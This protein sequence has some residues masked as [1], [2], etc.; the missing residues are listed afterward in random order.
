MLPIMQHSIKS[1]SIAMVKRLT[2]AKSLSESG[3][4]GELNRGG[5]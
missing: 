1:K 4:E 2:F 5:F 3:I